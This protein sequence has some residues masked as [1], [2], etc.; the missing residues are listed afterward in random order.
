MKAVST[1]CHQ[2]LSRWSADSVSVAGQWSFI[3]TIHKKRHLF[4]ETERERTVIATAIPNIVM[5]TC[6]YDRWMF[7]CHVG[8]IGPENSNGL[9]M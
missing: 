9:L 8:L 7:L 3:K 2:G 1:H 4:S 6:T 5:D